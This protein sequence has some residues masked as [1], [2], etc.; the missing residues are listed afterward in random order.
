MEN[1]HKHKDLTPLGA[2]YRF[3]SEYTVQNM[4]DLPWE[5]QYQRQPPH[6]GRRDL[7]DDDDNTTE[8]QTSISQS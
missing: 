3:L 4:P 5:H 7:E 1:Y 8:C 6:Y 2:I